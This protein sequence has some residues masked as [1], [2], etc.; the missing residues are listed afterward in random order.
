[1]SAKCRRESS[2]GKR[3][4]TAACVWALMLTIAPRRF[5][6]GA[7]QGAA[8]PVSTSPNAFINQYCTGCHNDRLK[9]G[10]L[11]LDRLDLSNIASDAAVW[12]KVVRK[13]SAGLMPPA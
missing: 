4:L 11:A 3:V 12:E 7:Q 6:A 13:M 9:T 10:G 2:M 8:P 1:M 5:Q